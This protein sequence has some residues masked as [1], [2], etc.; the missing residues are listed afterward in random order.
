MADRIYGGTG[1]RLLGLFDLSSLFQSADS[2]E[3]GV[4]NL[5]G[6]SNPLATT[7][8]NR[9]LW[10]EVAGWTDSDVVV[11][12]TNIQSPSGQVVVW[13]T[14]DVTDGSVV[15]WGTSAK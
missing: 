3:W 10:G 13:G 1:R 9:L 15:V 4:L 5:L 14:D 8:A 11:W 2:G 12:G 6:L 7:P